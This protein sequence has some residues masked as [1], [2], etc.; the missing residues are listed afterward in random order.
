MSRDLA[1]L[2]LQ[3]R[4][5]ELEA[6]ARDLHREYLH[7]SHHSLAFEDIMRRLERVLFSDTQAPGA[8]TPEETP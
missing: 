1:I 5:R 8:T 7:G 6:V 3:K 2:S 4:L